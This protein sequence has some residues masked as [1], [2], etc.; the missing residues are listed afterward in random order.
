M[1]QVIAWLG[2]KMLKPDDKSKQLYATN[3]EKYLVRF[4]SEVKISR[5]DP[6]DNAN[7]AVA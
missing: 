2:R 4:N 3:L 5:Q 1:K 6:I 7:A